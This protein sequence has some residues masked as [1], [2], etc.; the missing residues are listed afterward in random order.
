M[1]E[2]HDRHA[3][4]AAG[5]RTPR[6]RL[7]VSSV[8]AAIIGSLVLGAC[9]GAEP[10]TQPTPTPPSSSPYVE[11]DGLD[12]LFADSDDD[13]IPDRIQQALGEDGSEDTC[14]TKVCRKKAEAEVANL[15]RIVRGTS[16]MIILDSSGSM[17]AKT[18]SGQTRM[19]A[20]KKA[21]RDYVANS[22]KSTEKLGLMV[23]GHTG[24]NQRSDRKESCQGIQ[25]LEEIG[26]LNEGNVDGALDRFE[27]TGWTPLAK[28][29][30]EA[31][32]AFKE[33]NGRTNRIII[34]TD[35]IEECGGNAK[36]EARKI[37]RSGI[38]V[39][40]DV[41]GLG[42]EKGKGDSQLSK[43]AGVT[44]GRYSSVD[45]AADLQAYFDKELAS[46]VGAAKVA[47]CIAKSLGPYAN[48]Q[49]QRWEQAQR[50]IRNEVTTLR[51]EGKTRAANQLE[52][53]LVDTSTY[54]A[55]TLTTT[56]AAAIKAFRS[57]NP[58]VKRIQEHLKRTS[59][60]RA[61]L[62]HVG[63]PCR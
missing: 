46:W 5:S 40:L 15:A 45:D 62:E 63:E 44:G 34:V 8:V 30:R 6:R 20:A 18:K 53:R 50:A 7:L 49:A 33:Q 3:D 27:P 60:G 39:K 19:A 59:D 29:V 10:A 26:D 22:P 43:I 24:S 38:G 48:C 23:Y 9:G 31:A 55:S 58:D 61:A 41:V 21:V 13:L 47:D 17:A 14:A 57:D 35:G 56:G 51:A 37:R 16:T 32:K 1:S 42:V 25:T 4:P 12:D 28:S 36:A 2:I 54:F 11:D 52:Q